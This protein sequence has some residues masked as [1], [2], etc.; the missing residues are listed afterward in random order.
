MCYSFERLKGNTIINV[1]QK[2]L[3]ESICKPNDLWV[4]K[5]TEY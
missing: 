1:L 2:M 5:G 4:D 3:D